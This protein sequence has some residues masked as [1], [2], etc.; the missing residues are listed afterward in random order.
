[1]IYLSFFTLEVILSNEI[2]QV[3]FIYDIKLGLDS[4]IDC[5]QGTRKNKQ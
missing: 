2:V 1:M 5:V 3:F 4:Q